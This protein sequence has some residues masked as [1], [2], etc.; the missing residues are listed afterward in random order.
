LSA[1]QNFYVIVGSAGG[2]LVGLQ[3]VVIALI[4]NTR[5]RT[6]LD[7]INT[8]ATPTVVHFGFALAVSAIMTAPW[9]SLHAVSVALALCG[10]GGLGYAALVFRRARRQR[11]YQPVLEDWLW[12]AILPC[13][14]YAVLALAALAL[15]MNAEAVLFVIAGATLGLLFIGIRNAWDTVTHVIAN[16]E[17]DDEAG[18]PG[19]KDGC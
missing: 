4:A 16:P 17:V 8:F 15:A 11:D 18:G 6:Q 10:L 5:R 12:Y 7:A 1:W 19:K 14:L 13:G 3:F 2:A 9:P